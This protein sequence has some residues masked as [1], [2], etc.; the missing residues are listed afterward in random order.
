MSFGIDGKPYINLDNYINLDDLDKIHP[1][2]CRGIARADTKAI[3]GSQEIKPNSINPHGQGYKIKPLYETYSE[4]QNSIE[5]S[6]IFK[7]GQDLNYNELTSYLKY[8]F[9][10]YDLHTI[11]KLIDDNTKKWNHL[12]DYF[13]E[14]CSWIES[15]YRDIFC[16]ITD[17]TVLALEST[18]I[19][20]EHKDPNSSNS[21]PEFIHIRQ[22]T[23]RPF[24]ILDNERNKTFMKSRV[25]WFNETC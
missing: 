25:N 4:Y 9:G 18:G 24:Y 7:N 1:E 10:G 16:E 12:S 14:L 21:V 15:L 2:I 11:Y 13:P 17:A 5:D 19:P 23:E 20:W 8:C 3:K 6:A 22:S